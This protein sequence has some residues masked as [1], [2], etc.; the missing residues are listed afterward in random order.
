MLFIGVKRNLDILRQAA[1]EVRVEAMLAEEII[2]IV[3]VDQ[4]HMLPEKVYI[5]EYGLLGVHVADEYAVAL[6]FLF[7]LCFCVLVRPHMPPQEVLLDAF[8]MTDG[9][10]DYIFTHDV[11][12]VDE[13]QLIRDLVDEVEANHVHIRK[14]DVPTEVEYVTQC[15]KPPVC[16]VTGVPNFVQPVKLICIICL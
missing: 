11:V 7:L 2:F 6:E 12:T 15:S 9:A 1:E 4:V 8:V 5:A 3:P 13:R 14:V 10:L 16:Y